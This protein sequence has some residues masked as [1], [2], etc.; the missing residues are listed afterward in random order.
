VKKTSF[1]QKKI[2]TKK[3]LSSTSNK[4]HNKKLI[5]FALK[6]FIIYFVLSTLV[7]LIDLSFLTNRISA[8]SAQY[9]GLSYSNSS[10]FVNQGEF[11]VGNSCTGLVSASILIA[12]IF[13]LKKPID[14]KKILLALLGAI[15]LLIVNIPRV[16]LVLFAAKEGFDADLVHMS[17]WFLMSI[18]ILLVWYFGLKR[19]TKVKDLSE[20]V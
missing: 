9:L 13:A 10:I 20:L 4:E 1:R 19:M 16:M 6:F 3:D 15:I 11:I 12:I 5:V 18:I 8:I 7:G 2:N 14:K 17:T